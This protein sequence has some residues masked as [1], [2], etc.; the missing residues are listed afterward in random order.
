[1]KHATA[2]ALDRLEPLLADLR[3][4]AG[5]KEK[6]RGVFYLRSRAL[7][8]FHEDPKGMFA[9]LRTAAEWERFPVNTKSERAALLKTLA[10][11]LAG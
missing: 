4:H 3:R 2:E 8:H 10:A 5:L 7:L 11:L 1:M 9:D 6:S